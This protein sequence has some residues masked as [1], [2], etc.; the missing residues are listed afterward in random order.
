MTAVWGRD[1]EAE[2][3]FERK[4]LIELCVTMKWILVKRVERWFDV[5]QRGD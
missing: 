3:C 1:F 4:D 2:L 5:V